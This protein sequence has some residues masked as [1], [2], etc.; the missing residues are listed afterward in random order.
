MDFR[1]CPGIC[2]G[3]EENLRALTATLGQQSFQRTRKDRLPSRVTVGEMQAQCR[4]WRPASHQIH[5][6]NE[7]GE[8]PS[9]FP[10]DCFPHLLP[11]LIWNH[12]QYFK[13]YQVGSTRIFYQGHTAA[14]ENSAIIKSH[15]CH[16]FCSMSPSLSLLPLS[17][18]PLV[19][20]HSHPIGL[21]PIFPITIFTGHSLCSKTYNNFL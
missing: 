4:I 8:D 7:P 18:P 3:S 5:Q 11:K 17:S 14:G 10:C 1:Y 13:L 15:R 6:P 9:S 16:L 2:V 20:S 21:R 19:S 12:G